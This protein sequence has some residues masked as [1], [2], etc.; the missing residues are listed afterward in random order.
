MRSLPLVVVSGMLR[1]IIAL[2]VGVITGATFFAR[3]VPREPVPSTGITP[4]DSP[5]RDTTVT[6]VFGPERN[7]SIEFGWSPDNRTL[8]AEAGRR[9]GGDYLEKRW[10]RQ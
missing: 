2:I 1:A 9:A 4:T 3:L 10:Q 5:N 7:S 8:Y 6:L